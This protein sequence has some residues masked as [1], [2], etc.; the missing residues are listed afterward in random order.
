VGGGICSFNCSKLH[1][2]SLL[3]LFFSVCSVLWRPSNNNL[4]NL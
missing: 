1:A 3:S 2:A 4:F